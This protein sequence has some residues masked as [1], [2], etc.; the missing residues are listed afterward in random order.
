M[1]PD[2]LK[3]TNEH[4]WVRLEGDTGTIGITN[5]LDTFLDC[6]RRLK[7]HPTL[8]F[9]VV[10]EGDLREQYMRDYADVPNLSFAPRVP[11]RMVQ[12][13]LGWRNYPNNWPNPTS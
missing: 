2:D 13:S 5:A 10:G 9:L 4:E 12:E 3:Y 1:Y 8:H 11:K 7:N 6:A